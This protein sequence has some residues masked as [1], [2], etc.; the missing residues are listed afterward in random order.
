MAEDTGKNPESATSTSSLHRA[1]ALL[2]ALSK[3]PANGERVT[4]LA[5]DVGLTQATA[6]RLLKSL[7]EE[8]MV[9]QD[10]RTKRYR[11]SIAFFSLAARAANPYNLRDIARPSL[12]RLSARIGDTVFLLVRSGFD[13]VCL[14]RS[15]G[16]IPIRSFTEDVGGRI[17]LCV[18][19][20]SLVILAFTPEEER[21]ELIRFNLPRLRNYG[22]FDEVYFRT[23]IRK[24][25]D[26]G[27]TACNPGVLSGMAGV[28]VPILDQEGRAV[29]A[30]SIG[31]V[32]E[33]LN[34][35]RLPMVVELLKKEARQIGER[36][37]PFDSALRRPADVLMGIK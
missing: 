5:R 15:D 19:Q 7:V 34:E 9:E 1:F 31:T 28:A 26:E 12:L 4:Q 29:A 36:I 13:A 32:T 33:R 2:Q 25:C 17:A 20:A 6:H 22:V 23:E 30:L 35:E 18:G 11:L 27:Y 8:G 10:E 14:D 16:H 3:A 21:E 24:I 37:N